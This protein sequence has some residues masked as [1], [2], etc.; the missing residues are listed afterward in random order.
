MPGR[1]VSSLGRPLAILG[2][3]NAEIPAVELLAVKPLD[4]ARGRRVV[5]ES[6]EGKSPGLTGDPV[7]RQ[8][9]L[10]DMPHLRKEAREL[11]LGRSIAEVSDEDF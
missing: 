2:L 10:D 7:Y 9:D 4:G 6:D 11:A 8:K 1:R 5:R 3:R